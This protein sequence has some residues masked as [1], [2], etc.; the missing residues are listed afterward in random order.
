VAVAV[1]RR[2]DA[3]EITARVDDIVCVSMAACHGAGNQRRRRD[4]WD[5]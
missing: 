5:E 4:P 3:A 2:R 1:N